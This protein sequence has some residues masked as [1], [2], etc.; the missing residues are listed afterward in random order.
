[1][2]FPFHA[3]GHQCAGRADGFSARPHSQSFFGNIIKPPLSASSSRKLIRISVRVLS[4]ENSY[5]IAECGLKAG[6]RIKRPE[7]G[8]R[9]RTFIGFL[10][11]EVPSDFDWW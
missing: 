2:G 5:V 1:L 11:D 6:E 7:N 9:I 8:G 3:D 4:A 10:L